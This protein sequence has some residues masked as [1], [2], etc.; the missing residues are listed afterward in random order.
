L[1][2]AFLTACGARWRLPRRPIRRNLNL[3]QDH[4]L[5]DITREIEINLSVPVRMVR[6]FLPHLKSRKDAA[7]VKSCRDV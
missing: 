2:L 6:K 4:D 3:N 1:A 5:D 7:I